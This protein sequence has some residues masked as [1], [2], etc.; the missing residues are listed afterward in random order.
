MPTK[1]FPEGYATKS[2]EPKYALR[3][4]AEQLVARHFDKP[5]GRRVA[6]CALREHIERNKGYYSKLTN[7]SPSRVIDI[8][9][10][11]IRDAH[12]RG[13]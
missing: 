11:A 7:R 5:G 4:H 8:A 1:A 12:G 2:H 3:R 6:I 13:D 10:A 9:F